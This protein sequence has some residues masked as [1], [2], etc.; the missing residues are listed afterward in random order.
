[1]RI[2]NFLKNLYE[3]LHIRLIMV[4]SGTRA[5]FHPNPPDEYNEYVINGVRYVVSDRFSKTEAK[6]FRDKIMNF[7]GS[8]FAHLTKETDENII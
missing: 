5:E 3:Q 4:F 7:I 1:M 8:E 6:T 2:F